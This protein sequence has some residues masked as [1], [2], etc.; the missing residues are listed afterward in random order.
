MWDVVNSMRAEGIL[1][2][3]TFASIFSSL[4][5]ADRPDEAVSAFLSM[6]L[7]GVPRDTPA[8]NS[9]LSALC[10]AGRTTD[11]RG[12][13]PRVRSEAGVSPDADSFA[14]LLEG[15]ENESDYRA[16]RLVFDEMVKTVGWDPVNVPAYDSFL[17]TLVRSNP[18]GLSE[19][20]RFF[21][22]MQHNRCFPGIKFFRAALQAYVDT[23]DARGAAGLWE[24]LSRQGRCLADTNMYNSMI[25]L[26]GY[27]QQTDAAIRCLDEMVLHGA[28]PDSQ[29]YNVLLQFLLKSRKLREAVA[30]FNEMVKNECCPSHS[31][32]VTAVR[33]FIDTGDWKMG[34]KVWKCMVANNL[35]PFEE[36][37]NMLVA[38]LRDMDLLPEAC[39]IAEDMIDRGIK[40]SSSTLSKLKHSLLKVGKGSI[41]DHL[42]RK[43]K[44]H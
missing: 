16:A 42:L 14:I 28:F 36:S 33:I 24:V 7:H 1:S 27:L 38:K 3:A 15:C 32:C 26:H 37:G 31:N 25:S 8:L 13:L 10:R 21:E 19:A 29:T 44:S 43:W 22:I 23:R 2:L 40:L 35:Q 11:A 39:K 17:T 4:A 18:S 20:M 12:A 9:L 30:I 34:V 41:H 6:P 5:A